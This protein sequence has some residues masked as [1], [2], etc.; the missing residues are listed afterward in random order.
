MPIVAPKP[1]IE[2]TAANAMAPPSRFGDKAFEWL[3]LA[4]AMAVVALVFL[5]GWQLARGSSLAIQKFGFHFLATSTWDPVAEQF[6]ALP[7]IYGT[8]VSSLVGL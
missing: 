3:T 7:F 2:R 6:G 8:V 4:M 1:A 5:V